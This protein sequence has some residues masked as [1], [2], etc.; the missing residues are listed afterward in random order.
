VASPSKSK[1]AIDA[2]T[3]DKIAARALE[4]L[5]TSRQFKRARLTQIAENEDLYFGI[6]EKT[7]RNPFH[8]CFPAMA[9]FIDHYRSKIDSD[10]ALSF[11][12]QAEADLKKA[13]KIQAFWD[14]ESKSV[15]PT[16]LWELKHRHAKINALFAGFAVY[17]YYADS[18]P[19]YRSVLE[20]VS[21][22]DFIFEPRG[23]AIIEN[24]K[25]CGIDNVYKSDEDLKAGKQY[26]QKQVAKLVA[27]YA[28]SEH[29]DNRDEDSMR[30]NRLR[31]LAQDAETNNYV[32]TN[33]IKFYGG[34]TTYQGQRYHVLVNESTGIWVRCC[35]LTEI[36]PDNLWP[37]AIWQTNED[38]DLLMCKAPADDM[39]PVAKIINTMI[40]Q[41]LYNRQ[42]QNYGETHYD[43]EMYPNV[44]ALVDSRP[45][46]YVPVDTKG[47]SRKLHEGVYKV[48][49]GG[50]NATLDLVT[51]LDQYTGRQTGNTPSSQ[52]VSEDGKKVGVFEGEIEQVERLI[53]VK[54]QSFR[55]C[56]SHIGLFFKSGLDHNLTKEVAIKVMGGKGVEW[57]TL[58]P[59]DLK[60]EHPLT[61]QPV[62]GTSELRLK[63]IEK[64]RK[65][66]ALA[67]VA[68]VNPQWKDR[69][70]LLLAG[71]TEEDV[72]DAFSMDSFAQKELLAEAAEAEKMILQGEQPPL[73]NGAD[74]NFMQHIIDFATNADDLTDDQ[75]AALMDY[76]MAH[77]EIAVENE[78][79]NIKELVRKKKLEMAAAGGIA[80][81]NAAPMA[82]APM[83]PT[84][85]TAP[86]P[87]ASVTPI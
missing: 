11:A 74:S 19:D 66:N 59:E 43:A 62:G 40:N 8:E 45:D 14:M 81:P 39:R 86:Q 78:A 53:G 9:G 61:I 80:D 72:K 77:L 55:T 4:Q 1:K 13:Q 6:A 24:H 82:G 28:K 29:K 46:K 54:N 27:E 50:L 12:H 18:A 32:G 17:H 52:G 3:A 21:H 65:Q 25:F 38:P 37:F 56:L 34:Y 36:F 7:I 73:N 69:Q 41:E 87:A 22:Y 58:T 70:T 57:D 51:W 60:T 49:V 20:V 30:N 16:A 67:G 31:A 83:A 68:T 63:E 5:R 75:H 47:G 10:S 84:K 85:P 15:L 44:K 64:G 48:E 23:G 76:A 26:D 33:E 71:F 42:K 79:R 35:P 2:A